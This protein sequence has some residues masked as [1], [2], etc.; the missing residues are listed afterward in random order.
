MGK[1]L[2]VARDQSAT[3]LISGDDLNFIGGN[4]RQSTEASA[5]LTA[6]EACTFSGLRGNIFSGGSGTNNFRFRKNTADGNQLGTRAGPGAFEDAVNT[7]TLA[8][9]DLFSVAYTDDGTDSVHWIAANVEFAS[10]H[11]N[12]HGSAGFGSIVFDLDNTTTFCALSGSINSDGAS[13]ETEVQWK[14]HAYTSWEALQVRVGANA[15]PVGSTSTFRRRINGSNSGT[16]IDFA[17]GVTGTVVESTSGAL[18]DGDL[19]CVSVT[20][21]AGAAEDL[22]I[23][24]IAGTFKSTSNKSEIWAGSQSGASRTASATEHFTT[25]GGSILSGIGSISEANSR[26]KVGFAAI[27]SNLRCNISA[28]TT[29][30]NMTV[31]LYKNGV[32]AITLTI[33]AA[34]TGQQ[35]NSSDTVEIDA[36]DELSYGIDEGTSGSA[37]FKGIGI[38]LLPISGPAQYLY[39]I[40]DISSG[41]WMASAGSP[42]AL[43]DMIDGGNSPDSVDWAYTLEPTTMEVK[44][45]PGNTPTI[46]TGH[47]LKYRLRGFGNPLYPNV[48]VKLKFG[49]T[50]VSQWTETNVPSTFTDY[51][52]TLDSS[53]SFTISD[54]QDLRM[55]IEPSA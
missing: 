42:A 49:S 14:N 15:R 3:A 51:E 50:V 33:A 20:L 45:S 22:S 35:E 18:A 8:A 5:Q 31:K 32:A 16:Q 9:N 24:F 6:T 38:T 13:T 40:Q 29:G 12:F 28:S 27:V 36:D 19:V 10:G 41:S 17:P 23:T 26:I 39:P 48:L 37:T 34:A 21:G 53:P 46:Q 7:D 2:M 43:W 47:K 55:T 30:G 25:V 54:Y 4:T 44:F 52:R 1:A 11:G